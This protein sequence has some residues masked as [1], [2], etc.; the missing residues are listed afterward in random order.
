MKTR[1]LLLLPLI[2]LLIFFTACYNSSKDNALTDVRASKSEVVQ[3]PRTAPPPPTSNSN[4]PAF[5]DVVMEQ[6]AEIHEPIMNT[7][8]Y[9]L[10]RENDFKSALET[11]LS[12]FSI[13]VD[14]ASYSNSRRFLMQGRIPPKDA[15]RI[16]EFINYF[17]YDYDQPSGEHPFS[18]TT[19]VA[20]CPW[21]TEHRLVHIGLQGK[22]IAQDNLPPSNIVFLLDVS[23]SMN[24]ADK[25]PLLKNA[26]K[27]LIKQ[28]RQ[29]DRVAIVVYA[30]ASG[31]VLPSTSGAEKRQMRLAIDALE[32]GGSTAGASGIQLAYK[33][34]QD[35]FIEDGNNR[36]ILATDGDFN[37]GVSSSGELVRLI[38][39][40][41]EK[42]VFLSVLG[43]GTGNYKDSRMEQLADNGNGNYAYIDNIQEARK[44][45]VTEMSSTLYAVAKDV[46]LQLEFNPAKVKSYRLIGYENRLLAKEDFNDDKKDAGEMGAGH[47]VTALY[48]IIPANG[49]SQASASVDP[50]KYQDRTVKSSAQDTP[51][52]MTVKLR[53]KEPESSTSKLFQLTTHDDGK[54]LSASSNNFRFSA[55]VAGFG[56]LLRDSK[57]IGGA[58][59]DSVAEL[60]RGALGSDREGYRKELLSLIELSK[61]LDEEVE[62][63]AEK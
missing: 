17:D 31:V 28:L 16:E 39:E 35:N 7:E 60:V 13:D 4:A 9:A 33:I 11:P 49:N 40:K 8:E 41:R 45:L 22:K 32:A 27:M 47:T 20:T 58:T 34:A 61:T 24:N 46:K 5:G 2:A 19:E 26:F 14:N 10:I 25:L 6:E 12:T 63:S 15:I 56:M 30:G 62:Y 42:G 23:G 18:V 1:S 59:Y 3:P 36:V 43:F 21:N 29:E 38:E 53:Y 37:V 57:Y 52:L 51:D 54:G 44:V 50:L 55:G 48:E